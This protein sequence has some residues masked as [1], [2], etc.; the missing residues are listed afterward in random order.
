MSPRLILLRV[1]AL[2]TMRS[3]PGSGQVLG[4][5]ADSSGTQCSLSAS[6]GVV[7]N[8]YILFRRGP[9]DGIQGFEFRVNG[10]P[11]GW[12]AFADW[13]PLTQLCIGD[14]FGPGAKHVWTACRQ[15]DPIIIAP[16]AI[17][18]NSEEGNVVLTV[19]GRLPPT[20]PLRSCPLVVLCDAPAYTAVC[21]DVQ[22]G[23]IN[24]PCS[25]S[26]SSGTWTQ[27]KRLYQ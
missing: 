21:V 14:L 16:L 15:R 6:P 12:M 19:E 5:F 13:C 26:V 8:G 18:A 22:A 3:A 4:I 25:V 9:F 20:D 10:L 23:I 11:A 1:V 2:L 17:I 27:I 7:T 24:G